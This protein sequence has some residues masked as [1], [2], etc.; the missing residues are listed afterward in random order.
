MSRQVEFL[1]A[2][3]EAA[4]RLMTIPG[5]GP[6]T[7][8]ALI[9]AVG[10]ARQF[11]KARDLAAWLGLV[12]RQSST[13]GKTTLLGISKRGNPYVRRLLIHGARSCIVHLDRS[14]DRMGE[15]L[16]ALDERMHRNKAIVGGQQD[17]S[18][19]MGTTE[20]P[21]QPLPADRAGACLSITLFN[22]EARGL[23]S[24]QLIGAS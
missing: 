1:A 8:T 21:K 12:P 6:I 17:R 10:D 20:A 16:D 11:R 13:G 5:I 4:R 9:A 19:R 24:E 14:R 18:D 15:W 3:H 7:A 22:C 23:M 2:G